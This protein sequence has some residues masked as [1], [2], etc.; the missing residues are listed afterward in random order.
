MQTYKDTNNQL[1][2]LDSVDFEHLLPVGC[3]AIT[4]VE[5]DA[6]RQ[7]AIVP[8]TANELIQQQIATLEATISSRRLREATLGTDNGWLKSLDAQIAKL[9]AGLK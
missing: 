3:V 6:I 5:A 2:V 1:H 8:P 9:R 4:A 7:A